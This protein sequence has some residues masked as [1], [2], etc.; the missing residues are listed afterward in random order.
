MTEEE[1][2]TAMTIA[3]SD[4]LE[5]QPLLQ[6][7][8]QT[9]G[10]RAG[11]VALAPSERCGQHSTNA[12][13]ETLVFLSGSGVAHVEGAGALPVGEGVV[14]YIPPHTKHDIEAGPEGLR[15]VYVVSPAGG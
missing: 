15:Y 10:M 7:A 8:P 5:Y 4:A 11:R 3:L 12:H 13:E 9:C 1:R 14:A 6:G 2:R